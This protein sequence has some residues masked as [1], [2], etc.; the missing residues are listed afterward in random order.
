MYICMFKHWN[1]NRGKRTCEILKEVRRTVARENSIP[2]TE[3]ECAFEGECRGTCPYCEAEVRHLEREL[4]RRISLGK[5]VTVAGI[6]VSS[7]VMGGC[8]S[9]TTSRTQGEMEQQPQITE[10]QT[11]E[12]S[13]SSEDSNG[14]ESIIIG[15]DESFEADFI[16]EGKKNETPFSPG[17]RDSCKSNDDEMFVEDD[18]YE[19]IIEEVETPWTGEGEWIP[20]INGTLTEYL[21]PRMK[22]SLDFL[23][24]PKFNNVYLVLIIND[25]GV[26]KEVLLQPK[27]DL[28]TPNEKASYE[29]MTQI[30]K[31][32]PHW[33]GSSVAGSY[34]IPIKELR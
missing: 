15:E 1:M 24:E 2:L 25:K 19:G 3:H 14:E 6:A 31:S 8:Q 33:N 34:E 30:L 5:A 13:S 18:W 7:F 16:E 12:L 27:V 26:V 28:S 22:T 9:P 10:T 17:N 4:Q 32:M 29:E 23:R 11:S 21:R 20:P